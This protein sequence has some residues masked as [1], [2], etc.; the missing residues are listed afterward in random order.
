M[1]LGPGR[2]ADCG[3]VRHDRRAVMEVEDLRAFLA[4]LPVIPIRICF[5]IRSGHMDSRGCRL[6]RAY[7]FFVLVFISTW[8]T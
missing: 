1:G 8:R 7:N 3:Q 6:K 2:V 5:M 4:L